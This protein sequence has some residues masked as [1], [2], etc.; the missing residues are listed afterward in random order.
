MAGKRL[1]GIDRGLDASP[2]VAGPHRGAGEA[3][4]KPDGSMNW[5]GDAASPLWAEDLKL[6]GAVADVSNQAHAC[7]AVACALWALCRH[8][9]HPQAPDQTHFPV[10]SPPATW[11]YHN[12]QQNIAA[13]S[14][15]CCSSLVNMVNDF[16]LRDVCYLCVCTFCCM[17]QSSECHLVLAWHSSVRQQKQFEIC[18]TRHGP[19]YVPRMH[20]CTALL[21]S[22]LAALC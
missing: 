6:L 8:W 19:A 5:E 10:P 2:L 13:L 3:G 12:L 22:V 15:G 1:I 9:D 11:V 21:L 14:M 7:E 20:T 16:S 17:L 4:D 18:N